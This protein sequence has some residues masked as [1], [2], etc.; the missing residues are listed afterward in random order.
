[1]KLIAE[2]DLDWMR[3]PD[4]EVYFYFFVSYLEAR[5]GGKRKTFDEHKFE[6]ND[7]ENLYL[8]V[9]SIKKGVYKPMRGTAHVVFNPV[10]REIFAASFRDRVV[11]HFIYMMIYDWWDRHFIYDSYSGREGKGTKLGYERLQHHIR[12]AMRTGKKVYV[13]TMD[14][15]GFFMSL[16]RKRLYK[17]AMW[18]LDKQFEGNKGLMYSMLKFCLREVIMDDP[19]K[20][21]RLKGW[22]E[23]WRYMPDNKS[24]LKQPKGVGIVIGNLTSQLL[25]NIYLDML[26]RY[27]HSTL[28]YKR[29]GRYVDDF[30]ILVT[31]DELPRA[32]TDVKSI[33]RFLRTL[34]LTLHPRKTRVQPVNNGV[35]FLGVV[36]YPNVI[37][38]GKRLI[39]N[40]RTAFYKYA[41]GA[42]NE[43]TLV[44]YVGHMKNMKHYKC[45]YGICES[46]GLPLDFWGKFEKTG[47]RVLE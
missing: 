27:I 30:Y 9:E 14:I 47:T 12:S 22:P 6:V 38:P 5:K 7:F 33:E 20:G 31:E 25:S 34:K 11:H 35:P 19:V 17:R 10:I 15:Q 1:M 24:L 39:K 37:H 45:L 44:S 13:I 41:H 36:V 18:G 42:H 26:D 2:E 32:L 28:K 21:A 4:N 3:D 43:D 29:Y 46:V 8:L 16:D 23:D 40:A